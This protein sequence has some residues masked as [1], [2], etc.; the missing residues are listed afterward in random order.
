MTQ[1]HTKLAYA[2]FVL[3]L[4][5]WGLFVGKFFE[6]WLKFNCAKLYWFWANAVK[7]PELTEDNGDK[8][9]S[10]QKNLTLKC[11]P[12]AKLLSVISW[13]A[14]FPHL[15]YQ[16]WRCGWKTGGLSPPGLLYVAEL[17]YSVCLGRLKPP[18]NTGTEIFVLLK[19]NDSENFRFYYQKLSLGFNSINLS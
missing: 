8:S 1:L 18:K 16:I 11:D 7:L 6:K 4:I 9:A 12:G 13:K 14:R 17:V 19:W 3:I 10:L 2:V 5:N 15:E